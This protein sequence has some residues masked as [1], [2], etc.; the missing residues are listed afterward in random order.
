MFSPSKQGFLTNS[1]STEVEHSRWCALKQL[2]H[3]SST[4]NERVCLDLGN[5][6]ASSVAL[7]LLSL[8]SN[9]GSLDKAEL[10]FV[11]TT[12]VNPSL[13]TQK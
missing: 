3:L 11:M 2:L 9:S 1:V 13:Q 5:M 4:V 6:R 8:L 7:S 12:F 10:S